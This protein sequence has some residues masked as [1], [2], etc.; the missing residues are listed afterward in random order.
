ME[1]QRVEL[2]T[3]IASM[4]YE[5]DMTQAHIARKTG[6]SRSMISRY[7]KEARRLGVVEIR[8]HH[9][10]ARRPDIEKALRERFAIQHARVLD[11]FTDDYAQTLNRVG[12]LAARLVEELVTDHMTIGM[13]W[14]TGLAAMVQALRF[15]SRTGVFVA[16]IIGSMGTANPNIDGSELVRQLAHIFGGSYAILPAPLLVESAAI[17]RVLK[18][19]RQ[20]QS[21]FASARE[22]DL[23]LIGVGTLEN[24][25]SSLVRS[26]YLSSSQLQEFTQAG[27]IGDVCAIHFDI[28]GNLIDTPLQRRFVG[29]D[30]STL[31]RAPVR[32]GIAAGSAKVQPI[33]GAL[34]ASIIN[35]LVTDDITATHVLQ[36]AE[37]I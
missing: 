21:V 6:Y 10:L 15:Q 5:E 28:N 20:V 24:A 31:V 37:K 7:L 16:Q 29:I 23:A 33:L 11:G 35:A 17:C 25:Y 2:L 27:A 32:L 14:G 8:V 3:R 18:H 26:G 34:R 19:E 30:Y 1:S 36:L 12:T 13:S 22:M 4:Y 9:P